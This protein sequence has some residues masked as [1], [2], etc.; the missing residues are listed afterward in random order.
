MGLQQ[1]HYDMKH[2]D[3]QFVVGDL[4]LLSTINLETKGIP[5]KLNKRFMG[6]FKIQAR[7]GRQAYRL[8]LPETWKV[9]P[10]FHIALFKKWN[11][12]DLQEEE[13]YPFE[14][15]EVEE[16]FYEIE[17]L[18]RWKRI[19][20]GRRTKTEYLALWKDYPVEEAQWAPTS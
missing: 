1:K 8:L 11:A 6:A 15:P 14:E 20:R 7:I 3:I 5:D 10:V 17:K 13:E 16:P 2:R 18:L 4:V 9:H 19:K 12:I